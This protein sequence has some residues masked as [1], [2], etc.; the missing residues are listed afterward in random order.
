MR[1]SPR[2]YLKR[3]WS[4][5]GFRFALILSVIMM[6]SILFIWPHGRAAVSHWP[7]SLTAKSAATNS[8][9][10]AEASSGGELQKDEMK[11][12]TTT[13]V[14]FTPGDLVIYR[15][16]DGTGNE[17]NTGNPVFLDEYKPDGTLVQSIAMP[18]TA[19]G[20]QKQL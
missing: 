15:V 2:P 6:L 10:V 19:S 14:N 1:P 5:R 7:A 9:S 20:A 8:A 17:V 3:F 18:T 16:G 4:S 11:P 12:N 13:A